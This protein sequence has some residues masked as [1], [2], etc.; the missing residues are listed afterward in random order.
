MN[1]QTKKLLIA[2]SV[3]LCI[4]IGGCV[5]LL[6]QIVNQGALLQEHIKLLAA[7]D[8]QEASYLRINRLVNET[9]TDRKIIN[10]AFF[11]DESDSISFLGESF[12]T[13]IGLKLKTEELNKITS[14]DGKT[15]YITMTFLYTGNKALVKDFTTFLENVPYHAQIKSLNLKKGSDELWSGVLTIHITIQPV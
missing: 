8:A 6:Y 11:V 12:A 7:R 5:F 9:E 3:S 1:T 2:S 10:S 14:T 13:N 15:E 4:T